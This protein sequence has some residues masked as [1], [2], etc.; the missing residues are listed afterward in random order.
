MKKNTNILKKEGKMSVS[1]K[2]RKWKEKVTEKRK[3]TEQMIKE[4]ETGKNL[5]IE[6]I[7]ALI[8]LGLLAVNEML[9]QEVEKLA[10]KRYS[11]DKENRRWG[12]QGGSVYLREQKI[13]MKIPK[14]RN[15]NSNQEVKLTSYEQLQK[16]YRKD[17]Q[18]FFKLL[19]GLSMHKYKES[20]ELSPEVFGIS[21]SNLSKRFK[22]KAQSYLEILQTRKLTE[23]D[24][25]AIYIDGKR[26]AK[27]GITVAIGI[28][29]SGQKIVLGIEQMSSENHL[30]VGQFLDK[31]KERGFNYQSGILFII[32][33]AKG[34][35][36]GIEDK[37]PEKKLLQRCQWHKKNNIVSYLNKEQQKIYK[38]KLTNAYSNTGYKEAKEALKKIKEELKMINPS[39]ANSLE[40]GM[41]ETL[42]IHKLGLYVELGRSFT[43]TN[44]IESVMA[45]IEQYTA[46]VDRWRNGAQIQRWVGASLLEIEPRLSK[47][48]G[49]N[50]LKDLKV[51][52]GKRL[53]EIKKVKAD[54][55]IKEL[56]FV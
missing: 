42:T 17:Y 12:K 47:V 51:A 11:R 33:G 56:A 25:V 30:A 54:A 1:K 3:K 55:Q 49:F 19:N 13:P 18:T 50:Y 45:Q 2:R 16:P 32:D 52:I 23:Y 37:F 26:F 44:C 10:G 5:K 21:A 9:Q 4:L 40:E 27:E 15:K 20:A 34:I 8:P 41:E 36:K 29:V 28:T 38:A 7:Q 39:A 53:D 31:L 6:I 14:V 22:E 48:K 35:R 43:T 46:R 24:F